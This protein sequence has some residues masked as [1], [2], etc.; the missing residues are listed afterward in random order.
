MRTQSDTERVVMRRHGHKPVA[1]NESED[2][3]MIDSNRVIGFYTDVFGNEIDEYEQIERYSIRY[4]GY[5]FDGDS[6]GF[7]EHGI[8][9]WEDARA[10]YDAYPDIISIHDNQYGCTFSNGEWDA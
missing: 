9:K 5:L 10:I 4:E 8:D 6:E 7:N 1:N 2:F 3:K